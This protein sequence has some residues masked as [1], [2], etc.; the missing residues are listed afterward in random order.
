MKLIYL[1]NVIDS[2]YKFYTALINYIHRKMVDS[3]VKAKVSAIYYPN[4]NLPY[5]TLKS[6]PTLIKDNVDLLSW[7]DQVIYAFYRH[8]S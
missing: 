5:L 7:W 4:I 6:T 2:T 3:C 1:L 8:L